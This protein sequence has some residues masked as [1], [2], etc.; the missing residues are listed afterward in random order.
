MNSTGDSLSKKPKSDFYAC[1]VRKLKSFTK[2]L[3][4]SGAQHW[5]LFYLLRTQKDAGIIKTGPSM[6]KPSVIPKLKEAGVGQN[7]PFDFLLS[8]Q[9]FQKFSQD[10]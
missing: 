9:V 8:L 1:F 5:F 10:R 6:I 4:H 7:V 2:G 3:D